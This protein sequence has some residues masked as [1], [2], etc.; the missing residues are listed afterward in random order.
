MGR[1]ALILILMWGLTLVLLPVF[2]KPVLANEPS[3]WRSTSDTVAI[4]REVVITGTRTE[5]PVLEAPV[6]TEV[7]TRQEIEKT[8]ARDAKE[9]LEDVPG[10][11][12]KENQKNGF[13]AWLQGLDA[14]RVLVVIDGEP[15]T[16]STGS[17]V[18]LT[19]IGAMDI[20]RIEIVKGG[21]SALYGSNAMGG[22]INIITRKPVKPVSYQLS[23]DGGSYGKKN[24]SRNP[25]EINTRRIAGD[26]VIKRAK[27][28]IKL[29][30]DLRGKDGYT[31]DQKSFRAEGETGNKENV[32]LRIAWTPNDKT[33][34]YIAPRYYRESISNNILSS[35]TPGVGYIKK[36]KNEVASRIS[37]TAGFD[38]E[39]DNGGRL[40]GWL[41]RESWRDV[42][43]Q[44]VISTAEIDQ[45]RTAAIAQYRAEL[46]WDKPVG[47]QHLFTSGLLLRSE[48]LNQYA[49]IFGQKRTLEV[50]G[51]QKKTAEFYLQ[52]DIFLGDQWELVPGLRIQNDSR[53]GFYAAPKVNVMYTP[54]WIPGTSSVV[55]LGVGRG[56]R[57]PDLKE[58]YYVFDHSQLG[59]M[60]LGSV[61]LAPESSDSYQLGVEFV[62]Q[63]M[64]RADL[65]LFRNDISN[66][67][68]T[69]LN[70]D[71][72]A[73]T[74]LRIFEYDNFV[75]A[76]TQGAELG[77][78]LYFDALSFKASYTFL[79]GKDLISKKALK[80]RPR[81]QAKFGADY[82]YKPWGTIATLRGVYQSK[83]FY[84]AENTLQSPAWSTWDLKFTKTLS[85][86]LKIFSGID[87]LTDEHRNP[88][89]YYDNR[90]I[91]GRYFY[92][93]FRMEK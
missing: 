18:D 23:V 69:R 82:N 78:N 59:Y 3:Y 58:Q 44:D 27:G 9:A 38:R 56:Y 53:F 20:E 50:D 73:E 35:F 48:T 26:V 12:L 22:V 17:A 87:N 81:H 7:V 15:I 51:K 79:I 41:F 62:R 33:E 32:G 42:T 10:L 30:A 4:L 74:G 91:A 31:L 92:L 84:D 24:I 16:P 47:E 36:K 93:G 67:I 75:S 21:T 61:N 43:Q 29:N 70:A 1:V 49:D 68:D 2:V 72:S 83:A 5:K 88:N 66:L 46:Q 77:G 52:D 80:D 63:G 55:R 85:G 86:S 65:S 8:H 19:Q 45:Q 90:P 39:L 25:V 57:A 37:A 76:M 13:V 34:I 64:F 11:M 40:R 14:N 54:E 71:K 89:V 28:Y 6:R 60:V